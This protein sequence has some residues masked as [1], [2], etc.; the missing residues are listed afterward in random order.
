MLKVILFG[1]LLTYHATGQA[2]TNEQFQTW[3]EEFKDSAH[4]EHGFSYELLDE[5]FAGVEFNEK[6]IGYDRAQPEFVRS[7]GN[8][9]SLVISRARINQGKELNKELE[10]LFSNIHDDYQ[11]QGN[12][13]LAFW[14]M[15]TNFSKYTGK[16]DLIECLATLTFE[17]RR[18]RFFRNELIEALKIMENELFQYPAARIQGSWAGALGS[19]QFI[20]SNINSYAHDYDGDGFINMWTSRPDFLGS[21]GKFLNRVGWNGFQ[22]WGYEVE[23]PEGYDYMQSGLHIKKDVQSWR[24]LGVYRVDGKE[25][26]ESEVD[27]ALYLPQ[28]HKG[29]KF[30]VY[31]N[32]FTIFRWNNSSKYA[33][34]V[35][36]L[37]DL[38]K[39][40]ASYFSKFDLEEENF[41]TF[42]ITK[43][44]Q[45]RLNELGFD[46][47]KV[48]GIIG[49]KTY[50]AVQ[51][52]Q[53]A[54][55]L[56]ADGF[57]SKELLEQI[58]K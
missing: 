21:S 57:L 35:S 48:D 10:A 53:K 11:V 42:E 29:P 47:G 46:S 1:L 30:L 17:G 33:L 14:A 51:K 36:I 12:Y 37:S 23:L 40:E 41:L 13:L 9:L 27:V 6:V 49:P 7:L 44:L 4:K 24:E 32:Y 43:S 58:L 3:I 52:F 38:F 56:L 26:E 45:S 25:L 22:K 19:T 31:K 28:G 5:A 2:S 54:N 50:S 34:A 20:P 39:G 55:G 8:Y 16:M 18:A 15:E